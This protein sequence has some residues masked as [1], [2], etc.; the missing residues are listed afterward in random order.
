MAPNGYLHAA[1][2]VELWGASALADNLPGQPT[3][4][5]IDPRPGV[6]PLRHDAIFFH[7]VILMPTIT[8]ILFVLGLLIW[9][10]VRYSAR[11]Q[12]KCDGQS[13]RPRSPRRPR[14]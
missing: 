5:G 4:G 6:T 8:A 7:S 10:I 14:P 3:S 9:C 1:A 2:V 11:I 13:R 12:D